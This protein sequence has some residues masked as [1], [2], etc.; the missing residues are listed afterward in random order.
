[1]G[2]QSDRGPRGGAIRTRRVRGGA[3]VALLSLA[4]LLAGC[5]PALETD[6]ARLCR[7]ALPALEDAGARIAILSQNENPDGRGANVQYR[8]TPLDGA[9]RTH[10]AEC[11][12]RAPG[13]PLHSTDLV[14]LSIDGEALGQ[15][16]L[17]MLI[18]FWLATP[19]GRSADP[20]PLGDLRGIPE[21]PRALA[22]GLQ[23]A[24]DGLPLSAIYALLATAYSLIYGLIGRVNFAFGELAAAG[25]YAAAMVAVAIVAIAPT[26][27]L[28]AALAVAAFVGSTWGYAAARW[29]F[30]PL[31]RSRG[32]QVLVATVGLALF[33]QEFLRLIQ[34]DRASW[35]GPLYNEPFALARSGEFTVAATPI[36]FIAS[37]IGLGAALLMIAIFRWTRFGREWRAYADDPFA[38]ELFGV[39]PDSV[40]A[41]SFL[42]AGALAGLAGATMTAT[43]GAVGY[44]LASTLSLKA[45]AAAILGGI[46]SIPGAF[47]GA[48]MI[49]GF[50]A[51]WSAMFSIDYRD[52]AIYC[53][54]AALIALRP[55]GLLGARDVGAQDPARRGP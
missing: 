48:L 42:L 24:L 49:G 23:M 14:G 15:A 3:A 7:M 16:R 41:R 4:A 30:A 55:T 18:R 31:R 39:N 53:V 12:F 8:S 6:Q 40:L 50:E 5:A 35:M 17:F 47:V 44:G 29:V 45:L 38:A 10:V 32:Q 1:M 43:Y 22:Y 33:G 37:A 13:R 25:G 34:G 52:V 54:L 19:D 26:P 51:A 21:L 2:S 11:R 20:A 9:A 27:I 46:G 36:L 28:I